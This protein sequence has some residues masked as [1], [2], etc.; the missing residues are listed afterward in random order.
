MVQIGSIQ[1]VSLFLQKRKLRTYFNSEKMAKL[2]QIIFWIIIFEFI[3]LQAVCMCKYFD[4][5]KNNLPFREQKYETKKKFSSRCRKYRTKSLCFLC[6]TF[7][8]V[9]ICVEKFLN[10]TKQ[11]KKNLKFTI[12]IQLSEKKKNYVWERSRQNYLQAEFTCLTYRSVST[13]WTTHP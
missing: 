4:P 9:F 2:I 3:D 6:L 7:Y 12:Y 5:L 1:Q 8:S 11:F 13:L 10:S